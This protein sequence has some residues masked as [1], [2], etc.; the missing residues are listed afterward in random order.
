MPFRLTIA[1]QSYSIVCVPAIGADPRK[2]WARQTDSVGFE[3]DRLD[4]VLHDRLYPDAQV[5]LYDHLTWEERR[6]EVKPPQGP[7]DQTHEKS[8]K[9]FAEAEF[10]LSEYGV[11]EWVDRFLQVIREYRQAQR[12]EQRPILFVC[13]STGGVV[14]KLALSRK[15]TEGQS[16][17][18]AV[19]LGVTF[20]ATPHHGSSVL[21]KP[22]YTQTVQNHLGL[23][24]K[25]SENLRHDFRLGNMELET[26]NYKFAIRVVGVKIYSY[27]ES[28]VTSLVILSV[29]DSGAETS[30]TVRSCIV[31]C[32]S[33][34]L[35]TSEV[36]VEDEEVIPLNTTHVGT[37]RFQDEDVLYGYYIDEITT[38]VK[39]FSA[40]ER[41]TYLALNNDIMTRTEVDI[42]QFD[43]FYDVDSGG[44]TKSVKILSAHPCLRTFLEI[45]P[46]R[47]MDERLQGINT[48][49]T[50]Q[51]NRSRRPGIEITSASE[52][53]AP[54]R[55]AITTDT[56][57]TSN[58]P[59]R[60]S[61]FSLVAP[62]VSLP[63]NIPTR[64]PLMTIDAE[65]PG[66]SGHVKPIRTVQ[67]REDTSRQD[68]LFSLPSQSSGRFRWIH[69]PFTHAGWVSHILTTISQDKENLGLHSKA[70]MDKMCFSQHN[71]SRNASPNAQFVRPSVI[72]LVPKS[73]ELRHA[74]EIATSQSATDDTQLVVCLPYL[75]W[76]S[77]KNV[78]KRAAIIKRRWQQA[79]TNPIAK[80]VALGRSMEHK[81][82]WLHLTSKRPMHCRR[83][84]EQYRYP[85]LRNTSVRDRDQ[86]F[87]KRTKIDMDAS[88]PK[89][90]KTRH[91]HRFSEQRSVVVGANTDLSNGDIPVDEDAKV[92]MVDQ[93]WLWVIDNQTVIT[94]FTPEEKEDSDNGISG[95]G[96]LRSE[97]YQGINGDYANECL[98]PYDFAALVILHAIKA[99]LD[100][101]IDRKLQVFRIFEEYISIL[102]EQQM[103]TFKH[104][105]HNHRFEEAKGIHIQNDLDALLELRDIEDEL[106]TIDK[107][108]EEQQTCVSN[109][110]THYEEL[111]HRHSKGV[112]GISFLWEGQHFLND[113]KER[114]D[115]MLKDAV[116]AQRAFQDLLDMKQKQV[117]RVEACLACERTEIAVDQLR[118][119]TKFTLFTIIFLPLS[120]F[121]SIFGINSREWTGGNYP[122]IHTTF[123]YMG[124]ISLAV[125]IIALLVAFNKSTRRIAQR[126]WKFAAMPFLGAIQRVGLR[127]PPHTTAQAPAMEPDLEKQA[128]VD[129][130]RAQANRLSTISRTHMKLS[131]EEESRMQHNQ[132]VVGF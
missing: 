100:R 18:A 96:D 14:V 71:R 84:L 86:V 17:I 85:S 32:R 104:F 101:T 47:C 61:T 8:A 7:K 77:L 81:L 94:F 106:K 124:S 39:G 6:L 28:S 99:L 123:T 76:D 112:N 36:P 74:D 10:H 132:S 62:T 41:A 64:R 9:A 118:S 80:D 95:Q 120:F 63:K 19:C 117:D 107:L 130:E 125:I 58:D 68:N 37:S 115:F 33:G 25:M 97:I 82:I 38:I 15:P 13:H 113:Q 40:E 126:S 46:S 59:S 83:T 110:I 60:A 3:L 108:I 51:S 35:S 23:K 103:T 105:R 1:N 11:M 111:I 87:Y 21:S 72:Y 45:G 22:E 93:M 114:L 116:T 79:H 73:V 88:P 12:T 52:P 129:R 92:L 122:Y 128:V 90:D 49:E 16:D 48:E 5:H 43:D 75:H 24:W 2:T 44:E 102:T 54:T 69:V 53:A 127:R 91:K 20:F 55:T 65:D 34:K 109:I 30:M 89:E 67:F 98:N 78:R 50:F 4:Y 131:W 29:N 26:L 70:L 27:V 56:D 42:H 66:S 57:E 119:I 31:D 121:A